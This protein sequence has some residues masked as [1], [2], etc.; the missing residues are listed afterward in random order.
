LLAAFVVPV[1]L[2]TDVPVLELSVAFTSLFRL[3]LVL[4]CV[5]VFVFGVTGAF[6]DVLSVVVLL[7]LV[8]VALVSVLLVFVFAALFVASFVVALFVVLL[9]VESVV[10]GV[11]VF[12]FVLFVALFVAGL[13]ALLSVGAVVVFALLLTLVLLFASVGLVAAALVFTLV[14]FAGL[15]VLFGVVVA[16]AL[17]LLIPWPEVESPVLLLLFILPFRF[18]IAFMLSLSGVLKTLA[19]AVPTESINS[20]FTSP[21]PSRATAYA[22]F[23]VADL[24]CDTPYSDLPYVLLA[25]LITSAGT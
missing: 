21:D 13:V 10:A 14:L 20:Y 6:V 9:F 7:L 5:D 11:V 18:V 17:V 24:T 2:P 12:V 3:V 4:S 15:V 16:F 19:T 22:L 1:L 25:L 23:P 8:P